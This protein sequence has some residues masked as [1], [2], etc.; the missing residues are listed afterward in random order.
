M[1]L[2]WCLEGVAEVALASGEP[3]WTARLFGAA[4]AHRERLGVVMKPRQVSGYEQAVANARAT[5]GV[6]AF[7]ALWTEGR[8]LSSDEAR[9][10]AARVADA[11]QAALGSTPDH[12]MG[13]HGLT[14]RELDVLRLVADGHSDREVAETLFVGSATVRTHLTSIFGKLGVGSRTAAV[15]AARRLG[16]L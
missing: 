5:L 12:D 13:H 6:A 4:E 14:P 9:A 7:D 16:I 10:E 2:R 1:G 8:R 15:A 3:W 11:I